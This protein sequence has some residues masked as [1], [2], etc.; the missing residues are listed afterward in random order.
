VPRRWLVGAEAVRLLVLAGM[1]AVVA[2]GVGLLL[3]WVLLAVV[4]VEAFG[5]RIPLHFFPVDWAAMAGLALLIGALA[6]ILPV[7][8]LR[9]MPPARLVR[10]FAQER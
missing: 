2:T 3:A 7:E 5:W 1:I 9:R 4:N 6:A 8:R 10:V